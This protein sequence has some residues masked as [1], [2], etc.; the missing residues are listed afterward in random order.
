MQEIVLDVS[1]LEAPEPLVK[2]IIALDKLQKD[3]VLVFIHR[4]NPKHLFAEISQRDLAYE[5]IED[6]P[7]NFKM[8]VYHKDV[9]RT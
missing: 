1:E 7:N 6:T 4:L 8:K 2:G 3:Q 5:I 9:S